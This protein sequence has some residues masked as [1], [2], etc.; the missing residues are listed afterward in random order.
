MT[1]LAINKK[2]TLSPTAQE[3]LGDLELPL[4]FDGDWTQEAGQ[5]VNKAVNE[6][7]EAV[8]LLEEIEAIT[9]CKKTADKIR[10]YMKEKRLWK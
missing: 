10:Q 4:D 7:P 6:Y 3:V 5:Y 9:A 2:A 1:T 8:S